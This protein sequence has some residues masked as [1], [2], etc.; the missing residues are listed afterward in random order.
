MLELDIDKKGIQEL[1]AIEP[2]E[3][4]SPRLIKLE[5]ERSKQVK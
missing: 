3:L 4:S 1:A 2:E 5:E